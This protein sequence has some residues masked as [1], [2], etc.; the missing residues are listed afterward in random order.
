MTADSHLADVVVVIH[1]LGANRLLMRPLARRL[2][3]EFPRVLNWGYSSLWSP[4][5]RHV[6]PL[7]QLLSKL[8]ADKEVGRIHLVTH[9]MGGIITRLALRQQLP[10]KIGRLVMLAPPNRGS[11]VARRLAPLLGWICPPLV[12]LSDA[13]DSF[14]CS[15][16]PLEKERVEIGVIAAQT[17]LLVALDST[18]LTAQTPHI[19][20]PGFHSSLVWR[21]ETARRAAHFLRSGRFDGG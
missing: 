15:L 12:Q 9:S 8:D 19:I 5:E 3:R 16:L 7:T 14:V 18:P 10:T 2:R 11:H 17:D 20:L 21:T 4:L 13:G 6:E 1:G